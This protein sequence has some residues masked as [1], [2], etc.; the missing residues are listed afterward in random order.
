MTLHGWVNKYYPH[1]KA[2]KK[3]SNNDLET[4]NKRLL[5]ELARASQELDILKKAAAYFASPTR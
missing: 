2:I 5:K 4:E 1:Y 3:I